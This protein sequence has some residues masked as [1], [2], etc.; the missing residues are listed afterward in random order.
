[1]FSRFLLG[2]FFGSFLLIAGCAHNK[3]TAR[4]HIVS[5]ASSMPCHIVQKGETFWRICKNY[6]LPMD[7]V[8]KMN[9]ITDVSKIEA[10]QKIFL[11]EP[12]AKESPGLV[13]SAKDKYFGPTEGHFIWPVK[14]KIKNF[15][16]ASHAG[17]VSKGIDISPFN[18]SVVVSPKTGK[19]VFFCEGKM[20][21]DNVIMIDHGDN[22]VSI[23]AGPGRFLS[24][25]GR[26]VGQGEPVLSIPGIT[27]VS[28]HYE[29]RHFTKPVNPLK[30]LSGR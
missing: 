10:G 8:A 6:G 22:F 29:I 5:Q 3:T 20:G 4:L 9:H 26:V 25:V 1:M 16:G 2:F 28:I 13:V 7:E 19:I 17:W 18:K 27:E 14:G 21:Y 24:S 11:P 15:F 12:N 30:Y 23:I